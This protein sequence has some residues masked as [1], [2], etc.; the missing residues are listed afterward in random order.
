MY[1]KTA[2]Y[3]EQRH[4]GNAEK[5]ERGVNIRVLELSDPVNRMLPKDKECSEETQS[6]QRGNLR[7][8]MKG[9]RRPSGGRRQRRR[10]RTLHGSSHR[11][12]I[13]SL[14]ANVTLLM[15]QVN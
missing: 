15:F 9:H 6:R 11:P 2:Q 8:R 7:S 4:Y 3:K 13:L 1:D 10:K 5:A 12:K 14:T